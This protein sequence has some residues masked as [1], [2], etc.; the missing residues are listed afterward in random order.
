MTFS[1]TFGLTDFDLIVILLTFFSMIL[2]LFRGFSREVLGIISWIGSILLSLHLRPFLIPY[3]KQYITNSFFAE[4]ITLFIIF[5][6]SFAI[7]A[8]ISQGISKMIKSS[9]IGILDRLLGLG[10]GFLRAG[11]VFGIAYM[12]YLSISPETIMHQSGF[13]EKSK[14]LGVIKAS[15]TL[16]QIFLPQDLVNSTQKELEGW[17]DHKI[18]NEDQAS[19]EVPETWPNQQNQSATAQDL[20]RINIQDKDHPQEDSKLISPAQKEKLNRILEAY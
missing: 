11:V 4:P 1:N 10:F 2:G 7:L 17:I 3:V 5:F 14:T 9:V 8:K 6:F 20:S 18:K 15:V 12:I 13:L 16:V 19:T